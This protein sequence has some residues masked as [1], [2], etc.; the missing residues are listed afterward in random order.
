MG[1]STLGSILLLHCQ[2]KQNEQS[3]LTTLGGEQLGFL[4]LVIAKENCNA[5]PAS[6]SVERSSDPGT[7]SFQVLLS[8]NLQSPSVTIHK[9]EV[10]KE[11]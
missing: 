6:E 4:T 11:Q 3:V 9:Q 8:V 10:P 2:V 5:I 7:F 1:G